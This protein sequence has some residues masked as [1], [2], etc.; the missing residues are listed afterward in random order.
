MRKLI[1]IF[2]PITLVVLA[3]LGLRWHAGQPGSSKSPDRL[4]ATDRR[5]RKAEALMKFGSSKQYGYNLLAAAFLQKARETGDFSFNAKAEQAVEQS[6]VDAPDNFDGVVLK[7][8][9]MLAYHRFP[10]ALEIARQGLGLRA[11]SPDALIAISDAQV[12]LGDYAGAVASAQRA[13]DLRPDTGSYSR[14]SYLRALHGDLEGAAAAMEDA[15]KAAN[16]LD[17]ESVAWCRV[18]L[19]NQLLA[20]GRLPEA[21]REV[22][23]ALRTLPS[24]HLALSAKARI[25]AATGDLTSAADLYQQA[26]D[27]VPLPDVALAL[28]DVLERLGRK[29]EAAR[30]YALVE[31]VENPSSVTNA[32]AITSTTYS[33]LL[34]RFWS[35]HGDRLDDALAIAKRERAVRSDVYTCDLL[36]WCLLKK[37][38]LSES[39]TAIDEALRL[40][41]RD[42][43]IYHH[44]AMIYRAAGDRAAAARFLRQALSVRT[45]FDN[46]AASFSALESDAVRQALASSAD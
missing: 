12:E 23:E 45:S 35:D 29:E 8:R 26:L 13:I 11:E 16:P 25:R 9:V 18:Q 44:A 1:V 15:V 21:E 40:G 39:K 19:A 37:G 27:R 3:L 36:A 22:D 10:E 38:Q 31:F 17:E 6:L 28:G 30:Q 24:F 5:I 46:S 20:L 34:A 7:A 14:A 42:A 41:T 4:T 33:P 2:L 43:R 32:P